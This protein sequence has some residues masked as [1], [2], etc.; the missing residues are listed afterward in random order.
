MDPKREEEPLTAPPVPSLPLEKTSTLGRPNLSKIPSTF[1][2][3]LKDPIVSESQC[4]ECCLTCLGSCC[5][6]IGAYV[7]CCFCC[8][9]YVDVPQGNAGVITRFGR[10]YRVVDPGHWFVNRYAEEIHLINIKLH[11]TDVPRQ[12]VVTKD[13]VSINI[14]SIVYWHVIDPFVAE[15]QVKDIREALMQRTLTTLRDSLGSYTLQTIIENREKVSMEIWEI[16]HE[17]AKSW[18]VVVESILLQDIQFSGELQAAISA[19]AKQQRLG[20]GKVILAKAEVEAAKLMK[21][22]SEILNTPA[23]MQMRYLNTLTT[24]ARDGGAKLIFMNESLEE[25]SKFNQ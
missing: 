8:S 12:M 22:T 21:Q 6:C 4:Y 18:G 15:F 19:A 13:N 24:M 10:A 3:T 20:E 9:P 16:I 11:I 23:A 7:P 2:R 17:A 1:A 14:D 25:I 5:G